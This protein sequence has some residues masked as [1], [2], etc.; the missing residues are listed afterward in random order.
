MNRQTREELN[1]LS[2]KVFGASS[3]WKKLMNSGILEPMERQREVMVPTRTGRIEKQTFT[4]RK[5]VI[6]R[7]TAEE[8]KKLMEDILEA[9]N[10]ESVPNATQDAV[11]DALLPPLK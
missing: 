10:A 9:R 8:V 6:K 5:C 1:A 7:Y 11:V 2:K 4:D 3:K